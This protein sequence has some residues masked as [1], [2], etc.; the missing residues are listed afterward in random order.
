MRIGNSGP[1]SIISKSVG[2]AVA[3]SLMA[4]W[5]LAPLFFGAKG[6]LKRD[7]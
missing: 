6:F 1:I 7:F 3:L 5:T 4:L 2:V